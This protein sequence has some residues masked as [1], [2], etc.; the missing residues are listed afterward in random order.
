[1]RLPVDLDAFAGAL[2]E[3]VH[4]PVEA[5]EIHMGGEIVGALAAGGEAIADDGARTIMRAVAG[6]LMLAI[7]NERALAAERERVLASAALEVARARERA[8]AEGFRRAVQAQESER[9]RIARELHDEAGQVLT[10]VALHLR[11]LEDT[12][13]DP[14]HRAALV[15]LR[16]VVS[17]AVGNL[18]DLI[19]HLRPA[20]LR[21]HGL[22]AAITQQA[23]TVA[24]ATGVPVEVDLASL[25]AGLPEELEIGVFRVVQEAL[26]NV[27]RHSGAAAASVSA[28][29]DGHRLRVVVEDDGRGFERDAPTGRHGLT[30]M[31]ERVALLGGRLTV[32]SAPGAGTAVIVD[33]DL[34]PGLDPR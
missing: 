26:V 34:P 21:E 22:A 16:Q 20:A 12:E 2:R 11:V 17:D 33:V 32:D 1:M 19:T 29:V 18:H 24:A 5:V 14:A 23:G 3:R 30:G 4:H 10:A 7:A 13:K 9:A 8:T 6:Q 25:P 31:R 28:T 15:E 27:A